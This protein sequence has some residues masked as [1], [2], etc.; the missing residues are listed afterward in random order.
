MQCGLDDAKN[1][2]DFTHMALILLTVY[3]ANKALNI[4]RSNVG[5]I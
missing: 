1:Q 3:A 2:V 5:G 4:K